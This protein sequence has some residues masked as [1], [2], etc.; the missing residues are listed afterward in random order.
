MATPLRVL[1]LEDQEADARLVLRELHTAGFQ[2]TWTRVQTEQDFLAS[3]ATSLD[4]ILADFSMPQFDALRA[5]ELLRERD[6]DVPVIIVSG[7]IGEDLAVRALQ[8]GAT[9]I[10]SKIGWDGWGRPSG[11]RWNP[12]GCAENGGRPK[13]SS[14]SSRR[15]WRPPPTAS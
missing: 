8:Q 6:V 10:F 14:A 15:R 9:T 3:L 11:R 1:M 4:I 7:S 12:N 5:L 13:S 2:P